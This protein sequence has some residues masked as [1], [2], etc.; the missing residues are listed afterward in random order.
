MKKFWIFTLALSLSATLL[1]G[2][3][4]MNTNEKVPTLPTNGETATPSTQMTTAPTT[5]PTTVPSTSSAPTDDTSM[6]TDTATDTTG[7]LE[8]AMDDIMGG[9]TDDATAS[10]D[11]TDMNRMRPRG[12]GPKGN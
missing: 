2:C 10:T 5:L 6:P 11:G 1:M 7:A 9:S 4:C 8:G 12:N 3:G